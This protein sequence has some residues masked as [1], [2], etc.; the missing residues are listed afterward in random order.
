M[1]DLITRLEQVTEG[2]RDLDVEIV[3]AL[4]HT[5]E[6][7]HYTTS[8]DAKLPG[9][10]IRGVSAPAPGEGWEGTWREFWE[11]WHCNEDGK[12]FLGKGH[13]EALARRGAALKA[14]E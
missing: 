12:Y 14:R 4:G 3:W 9:E 1:K 2:S 11:A 10:N 5:N 8:L 13:T 6:I 7:P